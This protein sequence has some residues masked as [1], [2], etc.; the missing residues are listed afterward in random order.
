VNVSNS[1]NNSALLSV[2]S[3]LAFVILLV[4]INILQLIIDR[5]SSCVKLPADVRHRTLGK[6]KCLNKRDRY[7]PHERITHRGSTIPEGGRW[8]RTQVD[9]IAG[10]ESYKLSFLIE[11]G[12]KGG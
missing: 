1:I 2:N 9:A 11:A 3:C 8:K 5:G 12:S 4:Y 7:K 6:Y 10:I